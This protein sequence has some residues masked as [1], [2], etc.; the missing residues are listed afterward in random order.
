LVIAGTGCALTTTMREG[1]ARPAAELATVESTDTIIAEIDGKEIRDVGPDPNA[2]N[3][4]LLPP[5][6][7][8]L[9]CG[10]R[11]KPHILSHTIWRSD[12]VRVCLLAEAGHHY[13]TAAEVGVSTW[14]P[15]VLDGRAG[16][17]P[18]TCDRTRIFP[19]A[20]PS[21]DER[22]T[23]AEPA[24]PVTPPPPDPAED[25]SAGPEI[26][27]LWSKDEIAPEKGRP[28]VD[29]IASVG[30][31]FG[32]DEVARLQASNGGSQTLAAGKGPFFRVGAMVTPLW[33]AGDRVGIGA[34]ADV[35]FKIDDVS[36]SNAEVSFIRYPSS[37]TLHTLLRFRPFWY[38]LVAGGVNKD[39]SIRLSGSGDASGIGGTALTSR[40][41]GV[42]RLGAYWADTDAFALMAGL[43]YT[44]LAYDAPGA[45]VRADSA[46]F[47]LTFTWRAL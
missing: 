46:G 29:V 24:S 42:G 45:S 33:L 35:A 3:V 21:S 4:Y 39:E 28:I 2:K 19:S 7:H 12:Y 31:D 20:T 14:Q 16:E 44:R 18:L 22:P 40:I 9:G 32:G 17:V 8:V 38:V 13:A 26:V 5:G 1:P 47:W 41:G 36:A 34:G 11:K 15:H 25:V 30:W 37:L 6:P 10:L 43:E 23:A 27:R